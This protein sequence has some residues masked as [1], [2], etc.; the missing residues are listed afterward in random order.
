MAE[1]MDAVVAHSADDYRLERVPVPEV[2]DGDILVKVEGCGICAGDVK[3]THGTA[4]FWGGDGMPAY[5]EPPFI[6]GHEFFGRVV[7]V[8]KGVTEFREGDRIISEQIVPC[9]KCR[10]CR[11]GKYWLCDPHNVYGFTLKFPFQEPQF[12][13]AANNSGT[14][15]FQNLPHFPLNLFS[16]SR[17]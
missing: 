4:R 12:Q 2:G 10:Y 5:C 6:P 3:A 17:G 14:A 13:I 1:L 16:Q 15:G 11:E 9:G 8:G 7:E